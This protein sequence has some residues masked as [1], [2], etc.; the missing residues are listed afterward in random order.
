MER[1]LKILMCISYL[2]IILPGEHIAMPIGMSLIFSFIAGDVYG[3]MLSILIVATLIM[4]LFTA[5]KSLQ[6]QR[7]IITLGGVFLLLP[8]GGYLSYLYSDNTYKFVDETVF[9]V[10]LSIFLVLYGATLVWLGKK[11]KSSLK[12]SNGCL[13]HCTE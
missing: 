9:F 3:V 5:I 12:D 7:L 13:N 2:C 6:R 11:E 4:I 8:L 1:L 10:T